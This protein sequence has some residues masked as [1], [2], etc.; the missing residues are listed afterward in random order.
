MHILLFLNFFNKNK[1]PYTEIIPGLYTGKKLST[2]EAKEI[3]VKDMTIIDL[4][5]EIT[6]NILCRKSDYYYYPILDI[7]IP[8]KDVFNEALNTL[9][10][11]IASGKK[12]YVHCTMGYSRSLMLIIAY[13]IKFKNMEKE[14]AISLVKEKRPELVMKKYMYDI[15]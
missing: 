10:G 15:L 3:I 9:A 4:S 13:L 11:L 7:C 1:K 6:E 2:V 12:V 14:V 5:P 8:H